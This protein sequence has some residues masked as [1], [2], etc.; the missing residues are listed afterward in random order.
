M[1]GNNE[2]FE[3]FERNKYLKKLPS[4]QRVKYI[5]VGVSGICAV[6]LQEKQRLLE[7]RRKEEAMEREVRKQREREDRRKTRGQSLFFYFSSLPA[8]HW[9]T[10]ELSSL[11]RYSYVFVLL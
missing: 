10:D 8:C 4:M 3:N 5:V 2:F 6:M 9:K 11:T 1:G 7:E